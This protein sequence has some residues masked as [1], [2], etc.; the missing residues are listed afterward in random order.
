MQRCGNTLLVVV[1]N[2]KAFELRRDHFCV[3][4]HQRVA[5]FEQVGQLVDAQIS[6]IARGVNAQ[7]PRRITR[8][9]RSERNAVVG[10]IEIEQVYAHRCAS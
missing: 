9:C 6:E 3:V 5:R 1:A 2:A 4:E 10:K 8:V 7:K